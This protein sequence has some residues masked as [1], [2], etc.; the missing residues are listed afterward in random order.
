MF[1][2][3]ALSLLLTMAPSQMTTTAS[4][5]DVSTSTTILASQP[6]E[7]GI[8]LPKGYNLVPY[9]HCETQCIETTMRVGNQTNASY[10]NFE[11][12]AEYCGTVSASHT[13]VSRPHENGQFPLLFQFRRNDLD[14][15]FIEQ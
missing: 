12:V 4:D 2:N 8:E 15:G 5:V 1:T 3:L 10:V 9:M 11:D 7:D 14:V 6:E 13:C